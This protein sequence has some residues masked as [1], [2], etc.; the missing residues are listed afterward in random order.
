MRRQ[1]PIGVLIRGQS[2]REAILA[3][4]NVSHIDF[5]SREAQLVAARDEDRPSPRRLAKR[6]I[7]LAQQREGLDGTADGPADLRRQIC[8]FE[9]GYSS[10]KEFHR[11]FVLPLVPERVRFGAA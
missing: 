5:E 1:L 7:V 8:L 4:I 6:M 9:M 10:Q 3:M 2:F 11:R